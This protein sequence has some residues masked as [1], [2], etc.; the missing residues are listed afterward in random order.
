VTSVELHP[1][2]L[3]ELLDRTFTLY[4]GHFWLFAGIMAVPAS[5]SIPLNVFFFSMQSASVSSP[6]RPQAF[7]PNPGTITLVMFSAM[8][9]LLAYAL[10]IG[11]ATFAVSDS[12]LGRASTVR[13]AYAKVGGK[14]WKIIGVTVNVLLRF[15]GIMLLAF[16]SVAILAAGTAALS[17]SLFSGR[18][19]NAAVA[20]IVGLIAALA[21]FGA[22]LSTFV[23]TLRYAVSIPALLLEDLGVFAAI[24]RSV[25]LTQGRLWQIFIAFLLTM[26]IGYVGVILFQG[27]FL[28]AILFSSRGG[29][30]PAWLSMASAAAAAVGG[31]I[32]GPLLMIVLVL[33]YYDSRIRKEGF[34]LQF[35]ISALDQPATPGVATT[36]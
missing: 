8:F 6:S 9:L 16:V 25:R 5:F 18:S 27:P 21:I 20:L 23:L 26:I 24:R 11:A 1:L 22:L 7:T 36:S 12:Y 19:R 31:T 28:A 30:V 4:R 3:G 35:M 17:G 34:D 33:C 14:F 29:Q 13:G 15:Y 10:A 32:T 2:S